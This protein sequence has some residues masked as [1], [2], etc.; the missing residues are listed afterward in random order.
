MRAWRWGGFGLVVVLLGGMTG[1]AQCVR[2]APDPRANVVV[3]DERGVELAHYHHPRYGWRRWRPLSQMA[4]ALVAAVIAQEDRRFFQH[5]G[6]DPRSLGRA[7]WVNVTYQSWRQGGSTITQQ[8]AKLLLEDWRGRAVPRTL[9]WKAAEALIA[10]DCELHWS[11]AEILEQ[12]L[13]RVYL[14]QRLYGVEAAAQA[15]FGMS[16]RELGPREAQ[17]LAAHI[18][19]PN[20][21]RPVIAA[22]HRAALAP[23]VGEMLRHGNDSGGLV[24]AATTTHD[25]IITTTLDANLQAVATRMLRQ[26]LAQL[27][28]RDPQ[29][30]G[31]V[32]VIE[33]ATAQVRALVGAA[34]ITER[35]QAGA[36]N[37]ALALRQPGSALKPFTYYLAFLHHRDPAQLVMDAPYHFYLGEDRNYSPQNFDRQFYGV[38]SIREALGN[39]LNVPAVLTAADLG[40]AP[41]LDLYRDFGLRTL[42]EGP[43][44]YGLALTL[45]S[46]AV[47]LL[48]LTRAYAVLARGGLKANDPAHQRAAF[49]VT[50]ILSDVEARRRI[51]G[52]AA[53]M[54]LD[55][56][57]VAVKTGTSNG[58]RDAWALGYTPHYVVGVWVGH[59]DNSPMAGLTGA[60]AAIPIWHPIMAVLHEGQ[61]L[62][63]FP[64]PAGVTRINFCRDAECAVAKADWTTARPDIPSRLAP[65][66]ESLRILAPIDG[67]HFLL[68]PRAP[69]DRQQ[70]F[71][72]ARIPAGLVTAGTESPPELE[73]LLDERPWARSTLATP[74]TFLQ[75]APGAYK[76]RARVGDVVSRPVRVRVSAMSQE[77]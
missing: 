39:S 46:G 17:A 36:V 58:S 22:P 57:P 11:K 35:V 5:L 2:C 62:Q 28:T 7:L 51:F 60:L 19:R 67:D 21:A 9:G 20:Q 25:R 77:E 70:I 66:S 14:G 31:A 49:F 71:C 68:D 61:R 47:T 69:H 29:L 8:L 64:I 13:N 52:D 24:V 6:I 48:D 37:H 54:S 12:Y 44:H 56:Q 16:A 10:L 3:Q 75:L 73:W 45:G 41:L 53:L 59:S 65:P 76:L 4:P 38:M 40:T 23:H 27:R 32:V 26:Q 63:A 33:V 42:T 72:S 43:A 15:Y 74:T 50:S 30:Q 1:W 55:A 18:R 34:D